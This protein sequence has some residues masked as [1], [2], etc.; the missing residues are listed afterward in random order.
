M[1]HVALQICFYQVESDNSGHL[2][3][4]MHDSP[5]ETLGFIQKLL[6]RG[7]QLIVLDASRAL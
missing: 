1:G 3:T 4:E 2:S 7:R 5:V 6:S